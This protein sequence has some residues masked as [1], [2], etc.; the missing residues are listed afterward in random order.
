MSV[1][2]RF[3]WLIPV[4]IILVLPISALGISKEAQKHFDEAQRLKANEL[5]K[6]IVEMKE[7]IRLEPKWVQA[8][9][10][11]GTFYQH[12]KLFDDALREYKIVAKLDPKYPKLHYV[13][14]SLYYTRGIMAWT[15]AAQLDPSY[16]YK[17]DGKQI[18]YKKGTSPEKAVEPYKKIVEKDTANAP[19][20]YNL[21]GV[22]YDLA[23]LEY[24]Q[25]VKAYPKDTSAQYDLGLVYLE[26]AKIDKA[27]EQIKILENLSPGH[28][29]GLQQQFDMEESQR[30]MLKGRK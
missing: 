22:Y 21:R 16:L 12:K 13:L 9:Y 14:G 25:A 10:H 15:K 6:A 26:R 2:R 27:K 24:E 4:I 30:K 29:N 19:A 3:S 8:H 7:A 17:D 5:S 23:I 1:S 28:A 20:F 18:F 11:L